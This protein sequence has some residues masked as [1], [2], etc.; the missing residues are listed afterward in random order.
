MSVDGKNVCFKEVVIGF[1]EGKFLELQ[2]GHA[3]DG[4]GIRL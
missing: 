2:E 1:T 3:V 4:F